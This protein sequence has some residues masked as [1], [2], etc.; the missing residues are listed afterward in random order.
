MT[1]LERAILEAAEEYRDAHE[2]WLGAER[3]KH[4]THVQDRVDAHA[5]LANA[6]RHVLEMARRRS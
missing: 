5:R 1:E 3:A 6:E 4:G 2:R